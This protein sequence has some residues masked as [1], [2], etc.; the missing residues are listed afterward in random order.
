MPLALPSPEAH[1]PGY[2]P[3]PR[4]LAGQLVH[5]PSPGHPPAPAYQQPPPGS[6][7][8]TMAQDLPE[9]VGNNHPTNA[10]M[11]VFQT[12]DGYITIAASRP[13]WRKFCVALGAPA[14]THRPE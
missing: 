7:C 11:G 3:D 9:Q 8:W 12:Q 6:G 5:A 4:I 2:L 10:P 13:M 14:L 1:A